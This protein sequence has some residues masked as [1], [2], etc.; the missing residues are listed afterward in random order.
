MNVLIID[1]ECLGLDFARRCAAAGHKVKWFRHSKKPTK[2]G[3][4]FHGFTIVDDFRPHMGWA[5]DGLI[6]MTGNA[7]FLPEIDRFRDLGFKVFGPTVKSAELEINR[8]IGMQAMI[9]AGIGVP[10]YEVFPNMAAAEKFALKSDKSYVFKVLDGSVTDKALTYVSSDPADLVGWLRRNMKVGKNIK[11]CMLQEKI[12][13][14]FEIGINGWFG[15]N[16]FLP[17]KF[18]LSFEHKKLMP[19]EIG[20]NTGEM[21]SISQYV[22]HD[23]LVDDFLLPMVGTLKKAG[24]RGDFCVGAM[25]DKQ[26]KAWP[27]E[28]TCR[29]GWPAFFGQI[30]SHKGDPAQWMRDL[31]DGEDTLKV[32][33]DVCVSVVLAQPQFPYE[34]SSPEMV[35]GNPISGITDENMDNLHFAGVMKAIG[36]VMEGDKIVDADTYQTA[37]EYVM[38]VTA[39]GKT[40]KR[41]CDK[42]YRT[43]DEVKFAD[44]IYRNDA[45][46]KV[47]KALPA[48]HRAGFA[49]EIEA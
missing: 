47:I 40:V 21:V 3:N 13:A 5:R 22:D 38:I 37:D 28:M 25:I 34:T 8:G 19:G 10:P 23:K 16:G 12:D 43:I 31:M 33:Q 39:L 17:E 20:C 44:M 1:G 30:A 42:V 35:E 27:L 29:L 41:A 7:K 26:G 49:L 15:P 6:L 14:D 24:H 18:Q 46:D 11:K 48:M 2:I 9:D 4:G 36:P 45:G 32:S